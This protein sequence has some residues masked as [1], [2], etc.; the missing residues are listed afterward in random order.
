[1]ATPAP[2]TAFF[3]ALTDDDPEDLYEHAPCA[4][5]STLP[6]GTIVKVNTT[7]L[8]WTGYTREDL[9][10]L[11]RFQDLLPVG[12]RIFYETHFAPLLRLHGHVEEIAAELVVQGD[13]RLPVLVNAVVKKDEHGQPVVI[14]TAIFDARQR[15]AYEA[16]LLA[17]RRRAEEA[18]AEAKTLARALQ[19]SLLP[20]DAP[21]IPGLDV[22]GAYRPAGDGTVVGGDFYDVFETGRGT[23]GVVL[24]DACGKGPPAAAL[25]ALAR[26]MV[27]G[28]AATAHSP[29]AVLGVVHRSLL[30]HDPERFCTAVFLTVEPSES[31][32]VTLASAGHLLPLLRRSGGGVEP[33]GVK[34]SILGMIESHRATD[35]SLELAPGDAMVLYTDGITE[36]RNGEGA[37]FGEGR[38][39]A[40]LAAGPESA[41]AMADDLVARAVDFQG[42]SARD[43][44]AVVVLSVPS[45][46]G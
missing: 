7:F 24:G 38:L 46:E 34:G 11:R 15:R 44:M 30:R 3:L 29:A 43:D 23:W 25:T 45:R 26:Y 35:D 42:G 13:A 1:M 31:V 22:G 27:R 4:Y 9:V 16:Q 32:R 17:A 37:Y 41:Q 2:Q 12:D 39:R 18:E 10:G 8:S 19:S 28:A 21:Q 5:L 33:V 20:P 40:A 6:D 36:A 14:R